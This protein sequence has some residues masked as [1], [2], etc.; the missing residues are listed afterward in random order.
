VTDP[1]RRHGH[2]IVRPYI[3]TGGRTRPERRDLRLETLLHSAPDVDVATLPTEQAAIVR[4]CRQPLSVAEVGAQLG[5]VVT[6]V[7]I[8]AADL[9]A[10]GLLD[11]YQTDPVEIELDMLLRMIDRVRSL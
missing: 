8:V 10:A 6:V 9:V 1:E 5:L 3:M 7:S 11:V 4:A 2:D